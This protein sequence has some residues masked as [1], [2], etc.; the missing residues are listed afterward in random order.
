MAPGPGYS[1]A[2]VG[3]GRIVAISGQVALNEAGL[4]VGVGDP[5]AQIRQAFAN[6]GRVLDAAGA[7]F[8]DVVKLGYYLTDVALLPV[9]RAV[10]DEHI[11]TAHPPASTAV[12]VAAL[13]RPELVVEIEAWAVLPPGR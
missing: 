5:E 4:P 2:V 9:L 1:H 7:S 12:Q 10:R 3:E 13:F 6:L 8:A 11:D